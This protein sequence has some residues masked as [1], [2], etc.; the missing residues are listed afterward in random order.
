MKVAA[1]GPE[2]YFVERYYINH[3]YFELLHILKRWNQ[4]DM[5]IVGLSLL[6]ITLEE[7]E[8]SLSICK[9]TT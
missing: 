9:L 1:L 7:I 6:G 3:S 4:L 5:A 8:V 2:R